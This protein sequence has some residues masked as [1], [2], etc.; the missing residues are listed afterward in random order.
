MRANISQTSIDDEAVSLSFHMQLFS[1]V[2][3]SDTFS[4]FTTSSILSRKESVCSFASVFYFE[5][6]FEHKGML[7]IHILFWSGKKLFFFLRL[8]IPVSQMQYSTFLSDLQNDSDDD[9]STG[10]DQNVELPFQEESHFK[11]FEIKHRNNESKEEV[12]IALSNLEKDETLLNLIP[13]AFNED[14][15]GEIQTF[16]IFI[17]KANSIDIIWDFILISF[18]FFGEPEGIAKCYYAE[19]KRL[20]KFFMENSTLPMADSEIIV[21]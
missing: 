20:D 4:G 17:E 7:M 16:N 18:R 9:R 8:D 14:L 10:R 12:K 5:I 11:K 19:F 15:E 6:A 1:C 3:T 13:I 2:R 21:D